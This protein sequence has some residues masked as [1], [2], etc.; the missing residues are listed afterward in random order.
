MDAEGE[1]KGGFGGRPGWFASLTGSPT[2][3]TEFSPPPL[4]PREE[5]EAPVQNKRADIGFVYISL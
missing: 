1:E 2:W 5:F 4:P 3:R